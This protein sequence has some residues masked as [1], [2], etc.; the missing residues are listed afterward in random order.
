LRVSDPR[1]SWYSY[2]GT[3]REA[4]MS[5]HPKGAYLEYGLYLT[6]SSE[7]SPWNQSSDT[8]EIVLNFDLPEEA[9]VIDSWLWI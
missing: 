5:I 1:N 7:G 8:L 4:S 2:P 9:I 6:F 3:I